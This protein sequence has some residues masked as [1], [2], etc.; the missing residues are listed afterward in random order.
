MTT[1]VLI[2]ASWDLEDVHAVKVQNLD[3]QRIFVVTL[4]ESTR[5]IC[6]QWAFGSGVDLVVDMQ[7]VSA[8]LIKWEIM[9]APLLLTFEINDEGTLEERR[10]IIPEIL[11]RS[12]PDKV[13]DFMKEGLQAFEASQL[14]LAA[15]MFSKASLL[16]ASSTAPIFNLASICHMMNYPTLA[17]HY[18]VEVLLRNKQDMTSWKSLWNL[19]QSEEQHVV[20]CCIQA[21]RILEEA[22]D[23][24]TAKQKLA[25]LTGIGQEARKMDTAYTRAIYEDFGD[26]FESR[27]V[28]V[29][30]YRGPW[31]L[32]DMLV[33]LHSPRESQQHFW[34]LD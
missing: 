9:E 28:E 21:Y 19:A 6:P 4:E 26:A 3:I 17:S 24:P 14:S 2:I 12:M 27:L 22:L 8:F 15:K 5:E 29:L 16:D 32:H 13:S 23:D 25:S 10:R 18:F 20:N 31:I 30:G 11:Q 33:F 34:L 1:T 7:E